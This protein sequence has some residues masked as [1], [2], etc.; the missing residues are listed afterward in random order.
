MVQQTLCVYKKYY[1]EL[2]N[3]LDSLLSDDIKEADY[4]KLVKSVKSINP[5]RMLEKLDEGEL[6]EAMKDDILAE[7]L[8]EL[9][10]L[11]LPRTLA[12]KLDRVISDHN[13]NETEAD[14][15]ESQNIAENFV[16]CENGKLDIDDNEVI[17]LGD[18]Q[19]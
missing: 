7:I 13:N 17:I 5:G 11:N 16:D 3:L 19:D 9:T 18:F 6:K 12:E 10:K 4:E 1:P 15:E 2:S 8:I 14:K